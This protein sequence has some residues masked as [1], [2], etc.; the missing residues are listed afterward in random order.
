MI[1]LTKQTHFV[2]YQ[3]ELPSPFSGDW[4]S[5]EFIV[6]ATLEKYYNDFRKP[7]IWWTILHNLIHSLYYD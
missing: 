7:V 6:G 3:V 1:T 2:K 4:G 5:N